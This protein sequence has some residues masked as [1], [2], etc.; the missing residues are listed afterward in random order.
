MSPLVDFGWVANAEAVGEWN[1]FS[2]LSDQA[3]ELGL[4][5]AVPPVRR[6]ALGGG[7]SALAWGERPAT[8]VALHGVALNAHT[9]DET[10][11]GLAASNPAAEAAYLAIDLPGHGDSAWRADADY[12]P[13]TLAPALATAFN[14]AIRAGLLAPDFSL[15][16][17]SLGGLVALAQLQHR[18]AGFSR[19]I[20]VDILPL[21]PVAARAVAAFLDGPS[22]FDSREQIVQRAVEFGFGGSRTSLE[23]AVLLNTRADRA[24]RVAWKHHLG[25]LG[26]KGVPLSDPFPLWEVLA[27]ARVP[28]DLIAATVSMV[29]DAAIEQLVRLRPQA[30]VV[31]VA[32]GHNLQ[33]DSPAALTAALIEYLRR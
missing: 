2:F 16:G 10:L 9:W 27:H 25:V 20:L 19:L 29:D 14:N 11:L 12:T 15:V 6:V 28:I 13:A 18:I 1:E 26:G 7:V 24:G 5:S 21:N 4:S 32:G 33:E 17:H 8:V 30:R 31:R 3:S 22:S 23:R